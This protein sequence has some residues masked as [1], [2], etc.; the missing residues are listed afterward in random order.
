AVLRQG[1]HA[2]LFGLRKV[3]KTS[4]INQLRQRLRS[5][6]TVW[7]DCQGIPA[8]ADA[9]LAEIATQLHNELKAQKMKIP[10]IDRDTSA[11]DFRG[12]LRRLH[13]RWQ[14][15]G[16]HTPF[17]IILDEADKFFPDRRLKNSGDILS[18]WVKFFG[19]LRGLAQERTCVA[20]LVA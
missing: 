3:G 10:P 1:Q 20:A 7:I 8:N 11:A 2:G 18:E 5:T 14:A 12:Q 16:G 9:L 13:E 17:V 19:L 15:A 6:P 4:L